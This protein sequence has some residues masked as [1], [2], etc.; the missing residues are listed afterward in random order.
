MGL[1][2]LFLIKFLRRFCLRICACVSAHASVCV[3]SCVR[4]MDASVVVSK[5]A[6]YFIVN[7]R[8][9]MLCCSSQAFSLTHVSNFDLLHYSSFMELFMENIWII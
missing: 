1:V 4:M 9:Y 7:V 6:L 2:V 8:V 5:G 3:F